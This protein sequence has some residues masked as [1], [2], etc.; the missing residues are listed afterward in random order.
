MRAN[1][2][3]KKEKIFTFSN[4]VSAIVVALFIITIAVVLT[5]NFK[6]LYYAS[7]DQLNISE[8]SGL[9]KEDIIDNYDALIDYNFLFNRGE[10]SFPTLPMSD[11]GRIHFEEVKAIFD[12]IQILLFIAIIVCI[13]LY[14]FKYRKGKT[15]FARMGAVLAVAF[16]A[17]LG[18]I[19][20][21]NWE[22]FF[23]KFHEIFFDNDYWIFDAKTDPIITILPEEFFM[24][25]AIMILAV[26]L[27][28]SVL[29]FIFEYRKSPK[30]STRKESQL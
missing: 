17:V 9:S 21:A 4:I 12:A 27:I 10:L 22:Y 30:E 1:N 28:L 26:I 16:P 14:I 18:T 5:L 20:F 2:T 23:V 6:P 29:L 3:M 8:T 19:I 11:S 7:I 15:Y 13:F 24:Y 25:C